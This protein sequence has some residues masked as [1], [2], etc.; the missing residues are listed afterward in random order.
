MR[1]AITGTRGTLGTALEQQGRLGGHT[2]LSL[3]RPA[4]DI[5]DLEAITRGVAEAGPDVVIHP[6]A[7]TDVDGCEKNPELAYAINALGTRNVA[8]ACAAQGCPLVHI[9]T[10]C[11]FDGAA[12]RPYGEWDTRRPISV[13]G[14]SKHASERYV[15]HLLTRFYIVRIS[16]LYGLTG[17]HF[18]HKIIKAADSRGALGV[19]ADEVSTPTYAEDLAAALLQ[20]VTR[21]TYG[22]YH[23]VNGG[24]AS[25]MEYAARIMELTGRTHIPI[26]PMALADFPRPSR[27]P[28]YSIL[29]NTVGAADGIILRPWD[30]ALA[31]YIHTTPE[32]WY[33]GGV[34]CD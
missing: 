8:L 4:H 25:R 5:V 32:L 11:V 16:W 14:A 6:A 34:R 27:P 15:E 20:L 2:I 13:Y 26:T 1:I 19:V 17:D 9:S 10:N 22:W 31:D 23:L 7:Y 12:D 29:A 21:P 24:G 18:V 30:E 33:N 28:P 3:N